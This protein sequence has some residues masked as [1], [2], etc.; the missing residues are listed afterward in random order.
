LV[1]TD[2]AVVADEVHSV[3]SAGL[4]VSSIGLGSVW[5]ALGDEE[6][7]SVGWSWSELMLLCVRAI[8][9]RMRATVVGF[10]KSL[11]LPRLSRQLVQSST[12]EIRREKFSFFFEF[13]F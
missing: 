6:S 8:M 7:E 11:T 2:D 12:L 10:M 5:L 13:S 1:V 4:V 9:P 3:V